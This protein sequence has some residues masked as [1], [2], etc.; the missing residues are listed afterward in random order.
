M[1]RPRKEREPLT[2]DGQTNSEPVAI[3]EPEQEAKPKKTKGRQK[4][5]PGVVAP[6]V[7]GLQSLAEDYNEI[8][9]ERCSLSQKE[10]EA[11]QAVRDYM[12]E[13]G[14]NSYRVNETTSFV[15]EEGE[16]KLKIV[17]SKSEADDE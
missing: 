10:R 8:K 1:S 6:E 11:K 5:I 13:H 15:I 2:D 16:K 17:R 4:N 12:V 3:A 9:N 14:I 7:E